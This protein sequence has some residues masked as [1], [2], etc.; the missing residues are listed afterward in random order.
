MQTTTQ[1]KE[2]THRLH[3][4]SIEEALGLSGKHKI[5]GYVGHV[6]G[7]DDCVGIRY[8][9][10]TRQCIQ[11]HEEQMEKSRTMTRSYVTGTTDLPHAVD[12][13]LKIH[14]E[15][16]IPGYQGFVPRMQ[17]HYFAAS[18]GR[19]STAAQEDFSESPI[20][21]RS[22]WG[23]TSIPDSTSRSFKIDTHKI[24]PHSSKFG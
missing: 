18:F 5:P 10:A 14:M 6:P 17:N 22:L 2:A 23:G 8:A 4:T 12:E 13:P 11:K 1:P 3:T 7:K 20:R 9:E 15:S 19:C 16:K 24:H 21:P